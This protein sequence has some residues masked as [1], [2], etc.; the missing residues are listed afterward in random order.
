AISIVAQSIAVLCLASVESSAATVAK[1]ISQIEDKSCAEHIKY[2]GL[3]TIGNVGRKID[4]SE[5]HPNLHN[6]LL[7]L[8][9]SASEELK[10]AAA[11]A[12]GNVAL[13]NLDKYM[14]PI[15]EA[16][17]NAGKRRYLVFVALKEIIT[18]ATTTSSSTTQSAQNQQKLAA[19]A[20]QLWSLLFR[21]TEE[22]TT[23]EGTRNVIAEC[24][25]KLSL[26]DPA[27]F[28]PQLKEKLGSENAAA[29]ATVVTAVRYTFTMHPTT[30]TGVATGA[31]AGSGGEAA[32]SATGAAGEEYDEL[33]RSF[34]V[35]FL[36]LV[37][38]GDLNVRRVSLATL[39]SAAH[40]KPHLIRDSLSEL[41]PLL[42]EE[43]NVK[44]ELIHEVQMG[45]FK[46]K[47][48][49]GLETR[50]S[51]FECMYTLLETC[52]SQIEIFGFL[53]RV[54][55]GLADPS[56]EITVLAHLMLQRLAFLSPTAVSQKLDGTV[57]PL[58][59]SL[60]SKPKPNAVKQ[61]VE[62][63]AELVRSAA[64]TALVLSRVVATGGDLNTVAPRFEE[65]AR[66]VLRNPASGLFDVVQS[67]AGEV[68]LIQQQLQQQQHQHQQQHQFPSSLG[69]SGSTVVVHGFGGYAPMDMSTFEDEA[70][71]GARGGNP[72]VLTAAISGLPA[73]SYDG[74][75]AARLAPA[76]YRLTG[77]AAGQGFTVTQQSGTYNTPGALTATTVA[78]LLSSS[79]FT[80][81]AGT[82]AV[83]Y[84]LPAF[85]AGAGRIT[86][87]ALTITADDKVKVAGSPMP[88]LTATY[89][90]FVAG[91][92]VANLTTPPTLRTTATAASPARAYPISA[93][94]AASPNYAPTY[95][96]GVM[97]VNPAIKVAPS[98]L[99]AATAGSAYIQQFTASGG[100][101]R[102][103]SFR[104][105][106]LPDGL[107]LSPQGLLSGTP[108]AATA[109][110]LSLVVT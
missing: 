11:F 36:R 32:A 45:P 27:T 74:T 24:L 105:A 44:Q 31:A 60:L 23:E 29:R 80:P 104:A 92:T 16:V 18:G 110:P 39:N 47:V 25:G 100:S 20:P 46:H 41:L 78:V 98:A 71:G 70:A 57:E 42:Y 40:N 64:R 4:L 109:T 37:K 93:S 17:Q 77:L 63:N 7:G 51:A 55:V 21:N 19:L 66:D 6:V 34:I 9:T 12:L 8:F 62:K 82:L 75:T 56:H 3:L 106:G 99:P 107:S 73:R 22:S 95:R 90:G 96:A 58:K 81:M 13:G 72:A 69:S 101:G 15:L 28:L 2:L 53:Q 48:D 84:I 83:N 49:D 61:E 5:K 54:L 35:D 79:D 88:A 108:A 10:H 91:E 33:L 89:Q 102:G 86:P 97:T 67:V 76:N 30:A 85:A 14:P 68:E 87:A 94:G 1:F 38:D 26:S 103:Y 65:F 50:K 59:A 52:L 43:T